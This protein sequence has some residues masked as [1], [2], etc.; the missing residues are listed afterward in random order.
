MKP[1][2]A[3]CHSISTGRGSTVIRKKDNFVL[4]PNKVHHVPAAVALTKHIEDFMSKAERAKSGLCT[5]I[6]EWRLKR[7]PCRV[8]SW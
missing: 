2:L 8:T 7:L 4:S 6:R 3:P 1:A 5:L